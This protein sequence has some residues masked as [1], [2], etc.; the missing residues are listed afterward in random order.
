MVKY[1]KTIEK[2]DESLGPNIGVLSHP[3]G[4]YESIDLGDLDTMDSIT[5]SKI[6]HVLDVLNKKKSVKNGSGFNKKSKW[7]NLEVGAQC[8]PQGIPS[9]ECLWDFTSER[10]TMRREIYSHMMLFFGRFRAFSC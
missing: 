1:C 6:S 9:N 3:N 8:S 4:R 7:R 10:F 2:W 5:I